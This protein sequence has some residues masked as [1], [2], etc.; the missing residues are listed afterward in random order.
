MGEEGHLCGSRLQYR[1]QI[2]LNMLR[3][4]FR[5]D[6]FERLPILIKDMDLAI[7]LASL[8]HKLSEF[9]DLESGLHAPDHS[10]KASLWRRLASAFPLLFEFFADTDIDNEVAK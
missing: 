6:A 7:Q 10:E 4:V 3:L 2:K 8:K 9:A 1:P 5:K